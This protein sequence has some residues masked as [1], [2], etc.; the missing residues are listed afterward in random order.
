[1]ALYLFIRIWH[2]AT[3]TRGTND[4]F[5]RYFKFE[6]GV[7]TLKAHQMFSVHTTPEKF[8]NATI[9]GHFGFAFDWTT[10]WG[11]SHDY[12]DVIIFKKY[13]WIKI[14]KTAFTIKEFFWL[15]RKCL[16]QAQI[17]PKFK[18]RKTLN[19]SVYYLEM[20]NRRKT[21]NSYVAVLQKKIANVEQVGCI[22]IIW[23]ACLL[24]RLQNKV[25]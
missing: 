23:N 13:L 3:L 20:A 19:I 6:D 10:L 1:M 4:K 7:F 24:F 8:E 16:E 12:Y 2:L 25:N 18:L 22:F 14:L 5:Y 21:T 17:R 15:I 11:K 9:T